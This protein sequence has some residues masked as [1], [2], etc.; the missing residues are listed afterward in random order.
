MGTLH[1][2]E[3][4]LENNRHRTALLAVLDEYSREPGIPGSGLSDYA[5]ENV[6][7]GL[8][9]H[10]TTVVLLAELDDEI[11]GIAISFLGFSTF[12]AQ[13]LLNIHD[14]AVLAS[15]RGR[16]VGGRLMK[17][18]V[19]KARE[20]GCCKLTLEVGSDNRAYH[21]YRR[22]GFDVAKPNPDSGQ[23]LYLEKLIR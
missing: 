5:R 20:L 8:R 16:G 9:E 21:L 22:C 13:P 23:L 18:T 3:A 12:Y 1:I 2:F 17:A 14:F 4:D 10:P 6:V 7:A 15:Q 19:E 11:V